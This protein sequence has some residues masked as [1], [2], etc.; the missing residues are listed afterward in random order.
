MKNKEFKKLEKKK[1]EKD[2][3]KQ[4]KYREFNTFIKLITVKNRRKAIYIMLKFHEK[5]KGKLL[6]TLNEKEEIDE[7]KD[8]NLIKTKEKW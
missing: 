3:Q 5:R 6:R 4:K 7:K 1:F 8:K 2:I